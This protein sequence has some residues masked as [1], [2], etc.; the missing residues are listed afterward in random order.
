VTISNVLNVI[1][2]ELGRAQVLEN[3]VDAVKPNGTVYIT[4]YE[5][6]GSGVSR[7]T[8]KD[9]FQLN[10]STKDYISEVKKYFKDVTVRNKVIIAKEP[11]KDAGVRYSL[12]TVKLEYDNKRWKRNNVGVKVLNSDYVAFLVEAGKQYYR[13]N[14]DGFRGELDYDWDKIQNSFSY[15]FSTWELASF[16]SGIDIERGRWSDN[17]DLKEQK[18]E[19]RGAPPK[20]NT[21]EV[22]SEYRK[23]YNYAD[24]K[25]EVGISVADAEWQKSM[26]SVWFVG[27]D[28]YQVTGIQLGWG[29]DGEAVICPTGD[30]IKLDKNKRYSLKDIDNSD[31]T[32]YNKILSKEEFARFYD[33]ISELKNGEVFVKSRGGDYIFSIDNKLIYTDGKYIRPKIKNVITFDSNNENEI[34]GARRI[35]YDYEQGLYEK[36]VAWSIIETYFGKAFIGEFSSENRGAYSQNE[37]GSGKGQVR[38]AGSF[39][40][41][42]RN[43]GNRDTKKG[44]GNSQFSL[45]DNVDNKAPAQTT[46]KRF[47]IPETDSNGK[48]LTAEQREFFKDSKVVDEQGRL[49]VVYHGT[50]TDFTVFSDRKISKNNRFG[51]GFYFTANKYHG[52]QYGANRAINTYLNI[53]NH[54]ILTALGKKQILNIPE[55]NEISKQS[56]FKEKS[57]NFTDKDIRDIVIEAGYDGIFYQNFDYPTHEIVAFSPEQI[58]LTTNKTPTNSKDIRYSLDSATIK[59]RANYTKAKVYT[60]AEASNAIDTVLDDKGLLLAGK[61][62]SS[63][64]FKTVTDFLQ[65]VKHGNTDDF[66]IV[67]MIISKKPSLLKKIIK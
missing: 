50:N 65:N 51:A 3:A 30:V 38:R 12:D 37:N 44:S 7:S 43:D 10:K 35:I 33:K 9:Q 14:G 27:R 34:D 22:Q 56:P 47:S 2:T 23:S 13:E 49:L 61:E 53:K 19:R 42:K 52:E 54:L 39:G 46:P 31:K 1:D 26:R 18:W 6:D 62:K 57:G 24:D 55:V 20:D 48:K 5:G 66:K 40:D 59:A 15:N 16:W 17:F 11:I 63:E 36:G 67:Y 60:K 41:T 29:S 64:L 25:P 28:M 32:Y 45:A 58:K 4:V 8:G 21:N